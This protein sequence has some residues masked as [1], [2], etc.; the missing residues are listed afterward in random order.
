MKTIK[1]RYA[2]INYQLAPTECTESSIKNWIQCL[3]DA[4]NWSTS[5][6]YTIAL[7]P[8]LKLISVSLPVGT[9]EL[10]LLE[11]GAA[12]GSIKSEILSSNLMYE[13]LSISL[14]DED[15]DVVAS[16]N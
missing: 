8:S 4:V 15:C 6:N 14:Q 10:E 12:L 2:R 13:N 7:N 3:D 16:C 5:S 1:V 9:S 11:I